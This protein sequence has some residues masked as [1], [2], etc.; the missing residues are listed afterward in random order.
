MII[1]LYNWQESH[2]GVFMK[3]LEIV[4]LRKDYIINLYKLK[5]I[6]KIRIVIWPHSLSVFYL[7]FYYYKILK[8]IIFYIIKLNNKIIMK[9]IEDRNGMCMWEEI[10]FNWLEKSIGTICNH[11]EKGSICKKVD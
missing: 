4:H 6:S 11:I 5:I 7:T 10:K 9:N 1:A 2:L 3:A 8:N